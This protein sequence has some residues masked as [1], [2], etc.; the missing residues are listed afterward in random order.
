MLVAALIHADWRTDMTKVIS[1]FCDSANALKHAALHEAEQIAHA[2]ST[3]LRDG[4]PCSWEWGR[5]NDRLKFLPPSSVVALWSR[6]RKT[7]EATYLRVVF[8][9]DRRPEEWAAL[10]SVRD[11]CAGGTKRH[12]D[13]T[14]RANCKLQPFVQLPSLMSL[15][16]VVR[17]YRLNDCGHTVYGAKRIHYTTNQ[18]TV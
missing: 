12:H 11:G 13:G 15:Y 5:Q 1:A 18:W 3:N 17:L 16:V 2:Y 10:R 14:E 9:S 6:E 7:D 8:A 4:Q